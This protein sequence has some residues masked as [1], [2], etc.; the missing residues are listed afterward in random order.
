MVEAKPMTYDHMRRIVSARTKEGFHLALTWS[1]G[2]EAV[3]DLSATVGRYPF[4]ALA[5]K[6]L[7]DKVEVGEWGHALEWPGDV[8]ISADSL[9]LDTL[10]AI[11]RDD[12][13]AF[14]EWRCRHGLSLSKA[15][16]ALGLSRRQIAYYSNGEKT[17]PRAILLACRGWEALQAA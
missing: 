11:G 9:W 16:E 10:T 8:G 12:T 7:F 3:I 4:E 1:D 5:E 15:A 6:T 2:A 13:R 14:L 17:V